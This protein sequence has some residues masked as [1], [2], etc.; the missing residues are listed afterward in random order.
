VTDQGGGAIQALDP[1]VDTPKPRR[2][3]PSAAMHENVPLCFEWRRLAGGCR[4]PRCC[5]WLQEVSRR[6][7]LRGAATRPSRT[8]P[9]VTLG[10]VRNMR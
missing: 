1:A 6:E 8:R 7:R 3:I 9:W 2:K 4:R 5:G 10:E